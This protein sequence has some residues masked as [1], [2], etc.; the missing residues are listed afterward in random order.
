MQPFYCDLCTMSFTMELALKWHQK[1][2]HERI[3]CDFRNEQICNA[4]MLER[5]KA[6]VYGIKATNLLECL[7]CQMFF[8]TKGNLEKHV[9]TKHSER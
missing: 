1:N 4:F 7:C 6:K 8:H 9:M 3:K 5:H 2:V